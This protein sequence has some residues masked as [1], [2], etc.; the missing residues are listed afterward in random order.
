MDVWNRR[1]ARLPDEGT[2]LFA[3][4]LQGN[5]G[6]YEAL[7]EIYFKEKEAGNKPILAFCGDLV[8]GPSPD[9]NQDGAWPEH[10]GTPYVDESAR[11]IKDFEEFTR[12]ER[13]FTLIGNH[14]HA[15][16]G[17]PLVAKF[18][19]D[20]ASVLDDSLGPDRWKTHDFMR[21]FPLIGVGSCGV[22]LTHGAP[23]ATEDTL[24]DFE[25]LQY[26]GYDDVE[27]LE[28]TLTDTLG[29]L[30]WARSASASQARAFL[31]ATSVDGKPNAFVAYG[32]DVVRE[33]Y[34]KVGAEQICLSTSFGLFDKDKVYLR[35]D[36]A[37]RYQSVE[38]LRD[39]EEIRNL[40]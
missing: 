21:E 3:T 18:Y 39:G 2:L 16:I 6:D 32:H 24:E 31:A 35:I 29:G 14:E 5:L 34:D 7:K 38:D 4:D 12:T 25:A 28:M 19:D 40:Y 33:G 17:G 23:Y 8:H 30:L 22:T 1:V 36:L 37:R 9:M 20:E 15:H 10:L 11:L 27:C 13:A 26:D